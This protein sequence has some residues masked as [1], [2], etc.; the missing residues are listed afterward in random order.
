MNAS[1]GN[2]VRKVWKGIVAFCVVIAAALPYLGCS[3][4]DA[5]PSAPPEDPPPVTVMD[6]PREEP[7][8]TDAEGEPRLRQ[9][10]R[11]EAM[12]AE[13]EFTLYT[14]PG[15][16]STDEIMR[17]ADEAFQAVVEL[18]ERISRWRP[19]S[20]VSRVNNQAG[21][22]PVQVA[23][24]LVDLILLSK[25]AHADTDGAFDITV[26]PLIKLWGFYKGEG[27]LPSPEELEPALA[28]VGL[29]KVRVDPDERM[30]ALERE[31]M[32]IDL[33]G[34]GKGL[35][36][37]YA[38]EVMRRYGVSSA[39]LHAGTST[40]L[41]IGAPP[42]AP[43][44]T[45]RVRDPYNKEGVVDEVLLND[46][47]LSTSAGYE[48]WFELDGKKYCHIFDPRT[49]MPVEGMVSTTAVAPTGALSDALST[50]FFVMGV[51]RTEQ[52]C[53]EHPEVRAVLV[54]ESEGPL[55]SRRI[56]FGA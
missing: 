42:D 44:W 27:H 4:P 17:I 20:Q 43:G 56:G 6:P 25:Q 41:A 54:P 48:K 19:Q 14:E 28:L 7:D 51:E 55:E 33:G 52:Y 5:P 23:R 16:K 32:M 40:V 36:L 21:G 45:V 8:P 2:R 9:T 3:G 47:A 1:P 39:L 30:V 37:D 12:N 34:I 35:A 26:G 53:R 10:M 31:G 46:E 15:A 29:D 50:A 38:A 13:F 24:E 18:E 49:G 11:Y 22:D